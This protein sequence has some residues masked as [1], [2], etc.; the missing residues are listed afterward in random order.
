MICCTCQYYFCFYI[1]SD[2]LYIDF[3]LLAGLVISLSLSQH[4]CRCQTNTLFNQSPFQ[5]QQHTQL[6]Q[7]LQQQQQQQQ[8]PRQQQQ[9]FP[10]TLNTLQPLG[11]ALG[12]ISPISPLT[13]IGAQNYVPITAYQNDLNY[14]GSFSYGYA[15]ADGTTAQ[16]QGYVKNLGLGED[17]EAQV[18]QGSYSYTSPEGT[19]I[20]VRYIA[21]EN[22]FRAEGAHIPTPPPIPDAIAKSLQYISSVQPYQQGINPNLNPY[23]TPFRQFSGGGQPLR[24]GQQQQLT[25]FQLQQ[26][27]QRTYQQQLAGQLQP[28]FSQFPG[29]QQQQQQSNA[30]F[31]GGLAGQGQLPGQ[32]GDLS[33]QNFTQQPQNLQQDQQQQQKHQQQQQHNQQQQQ[34]Q[35][36]QLATQELRAR[37]NQLVNPFGYNQYRRY[38]KAVA[39]KN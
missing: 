26:Q 23:Q 21:D 19:P 13:G 25:P 35:Q 17:V 31:G 27:Q 10:N 3:Q 7:Q 16:A 6:R 1:T 8:Q 4:T 22:G 38:K 18:V 9:G 5:R 2:Y 34:Q 29:V 33:G 14:D 20:T 37:P 28:P 15:S 24:P 30:F 39:P 11:T 12:G 32:L 36:Q